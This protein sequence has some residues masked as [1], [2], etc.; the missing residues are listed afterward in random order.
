MAAPVYPPENCKYCQ[1]CGRNAYGFGSKGQLDLYNWRGCRPRIAG[2]KGLG[3]CRR[4]RRCMNPG[5]P[6]RIIARFGR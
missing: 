1:I 3:R 4:L 5:L 2:L 6:G